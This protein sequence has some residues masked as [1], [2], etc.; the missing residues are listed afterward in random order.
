[1]SWRNILH[2]IELFQAALRLPCFTR[3]GFKTAHKVF[4]LS[5]PSLLLSIERSLECHALGALALVRA[6]VTAV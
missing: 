2:A 1:M 4:D 6:V 5:T 3:F